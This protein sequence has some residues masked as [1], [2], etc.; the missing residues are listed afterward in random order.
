M[1]IIRISYLI[2]IWKHF[3]QHH[4]NSRSSK[5]RDEPKLNTFKLA[6]LI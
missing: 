4:R 1:F 3:F 5:S 6:K 2:F